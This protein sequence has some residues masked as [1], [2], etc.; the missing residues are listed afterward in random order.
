MVIRCDA[1]RIELDFTESCANHLFTLGRFEPAIVRLM[2]SLLS[3]GMTVMD[4]GTN[5]GFF[6]LIAARCVGPEGRVIA[7]E[8]DSDNLR[9]LR[10]NIACNEAGNVSVEAV[11]VAASHGE[12]TFH[13]GN[14]DEVGS[15]LFQDTHA[16]HEEV[17]VPTIGLDRYLDEKGIS[18]VDFLKMDIE[19]AEIMAIQGM[20]EGLAAGLYGHLIIE[21]HG[22][23][24]GGVGERR[25]EFLEPL[26]HAGYKI[27]RVLR[28]WN[29]W[30]ELRFGRGI[31]PFTSDYPIYSRPHLYCEPPGAQ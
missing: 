31:V 10:R 11:A 7:C 13:L 19:G 20:R 22:K 6:A 27:Y 23:S 9:R 2:R 3:P 1:G 18:K 15:L 8:P 29:P 17:T 24:E 4:L 21:F 5:N 14:R 12:A 28:H 25:E 30:A 26:Y 16:R